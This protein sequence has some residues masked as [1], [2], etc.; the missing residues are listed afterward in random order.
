MGGVMCN[1]CYGG[2]GSS[3]SLKLKQSAA[4]AVGGAL[5]VGA[6]PVALG[7][8]GVTGAGI[9]ASSMLAKMMSLA[10]IANRGGVAMGSLVATLQSVSAAVLSTSSNMLLCS[11]D[12][13]FEAW[14]GNSTQLP[15]L[16]T[17]P[18]AEG[19]QPKEN[20]LQAEPPKPPLGSEKHEE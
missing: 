8:L 9:T 13:T 12:S 15:P 10:A 16:L 1:G 17:E 2:G 18:R 20:V 7:A 19:D 11:M 4:A 14:L 5:A 3:G 6:V